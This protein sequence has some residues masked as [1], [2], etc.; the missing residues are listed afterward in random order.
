MH[1]RVGKM[2]KKRL[3]LIGGPFQHAKTSTLDK[4]SKYLEWDFESK[5]N[6]ITFY[7]DYQITEGLQDRDDGKV[8]YGWLMESRAI[9]PNLVDYVI[10]NKD[11]FIQTYEAIFTHNQRLLKLDDKFKWVPAYGLYIDDPKI[12]EKT[13]LLSMI[14][15]NKT[16]TK[17]HLLRNHLAK[18]WK[19][20]L[21]LY[22]RGYNE[23]E[24]KEEGL[25]DYMFSVAIEND[26]YE[27]Y[28]TEKILDCFAV[29]TIPVYLG[30]PDIGN[31]F[32]MDGIIV[33][34]K[35]FKMSDLTENLYY[36]KIDA[37]RDNFDRVLEYDVLEDWI[38]KEYL[39]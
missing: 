28:F 15:S 1:G 2:K 25:Q 33:L 12:C 34:D 14:T 36:D 6:D 35:E 31:H 3:N 39:L 16:M 20:H 26:C 32:N 24:K 37:V 13:K 9:V 8:K 5:Q 4:E 22:G 10:A 30:A 21:D 7:V 18:K 19:S 23:I 27:T 11:S 38:Y 17:N 29:G